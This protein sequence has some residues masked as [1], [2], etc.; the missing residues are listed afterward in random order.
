MS[1]RRF[2]PITTKING[3]LIFTLIVG[4]GAISFY[5]FATITGNIDDSIEQNFAEQGEIFSAAIEK[6][7]L[8][9]QAELAVEFFDT[10]QQSPSEL[11]QVQL[12]R[13]S[14]KLAFSD[15]TTI[16]NVVNSNARYIEISSRVPATSIIPAA[17]RRISP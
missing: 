11:F 3:I 6:Y 1:T 2:L 9:G 12:I 13:T 16:E 14:G 15:L 17:E 7:M 8:P 4:I 10:L 5:F